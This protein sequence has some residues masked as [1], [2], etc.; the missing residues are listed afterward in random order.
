M[1]FHFI[2]LTLFLVQAIKAQDNIS[3]L[4]S[5]VETVER[6]EQLSNLKKVKFDSLSII[7]TYEE[8][9]RKIDFGFEHHR[10]L[11]MSWNRDLKL[12]LISKDQELKIIWISEFDSSREK[13]SNVLNIVRDSSFVKNYISN[14]NNFYKTNLNKS[15]FENQFLSEY[16]VGFGCGSWNLND[17]EKDFGKGFRSRKLDKRKNRK[18]YLN[19][20][21]SFSPEV[22]TYGTIGLLSIIKKY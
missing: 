6:V 5:F 7:T 16:V 18:H 14:H 8:L 21:K 10:I 19:W 2:I 1:R 4:K 3:D 17:I 9:K 13:H 20:L 12:N 11:I 15:D 22:Q